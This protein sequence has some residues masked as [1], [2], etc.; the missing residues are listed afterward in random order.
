MR[1][2]VTEE[3]AREIRDLAER[4]H[5]PLEWQIRYLI[6]LGLEQVRGNAGKGLLAES[7]PAVSPSVPAKP[8]QRRIA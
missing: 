7:R 3:M 4:D 6:S 5:R 2:R 8:P 1:L